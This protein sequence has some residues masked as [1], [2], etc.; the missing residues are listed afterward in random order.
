ME[1]LLPV[2]TITACQRSLVPVSKHIVPQYWAADSFLNK[3]VNKS[4][5]GKKLDLHSEVP[6]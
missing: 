4:L 5:T 3:K 2:S 6:P 1:Q